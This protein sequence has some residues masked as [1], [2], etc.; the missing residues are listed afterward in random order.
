MTKPK[1]IIATIPG[2]IA[3]DD[4][5]ALREVSDVTYYEASGLTQDEL[6][7]RC[8][9]FDY[10]MLNY[11]VV[12]RLDEVFYS[13]PNIKALKAISTDITGMEW[14]NPALAARHGVT[15]LNTPRYS[16]ESVAESILCEVLL[17]SRKV[18]AA[19]RDLVRGAEPEARKGIN[20]KDR[21]AGVV[22]LG[23]IGSRVAELLAAVGMNVLGWNRTPRQLPNVSAVSLEELFKRSEVICLG[24]KT[25]TQGKSSTVGFVGKELLDLCRPGLILVNLAGRQLV[26]HDALLP[27]LETG[28]IVGYSVTR[29]EKTLGLAIAKFDCVSMP[30]ANAWF[31]D[32]SLRMLRQIWAGNII[33]AIAGNPQNVFAE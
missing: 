25:V 28:R 22:G 32:E 3:E 2:M 29:S 16:T 20:L 15:L 12:K 19:Y 27:Y 17:H 33:S 1:T 9:G 18:H 31:S 6:A 13:N 26:D 5:V 24:L 30:P 23:S 8:S 4:L 14:A 11:D 7:E 21:T 10:L